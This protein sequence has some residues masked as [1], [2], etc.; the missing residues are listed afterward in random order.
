MVGRAE[1]SVQAARSRSGGV[2]MLTWR[3]GILL[4]AGAAV[5]LSLG[6]ARAE[7][8]VKIGLIVPMTGGQASTGKQIDNAVKLYMQQK[9]DPVAGKKIEVILKD[10]AAVPA[11][12]KRPAQELIVNDK[13]N[14]IAGFG[15]TP[16]PL[17]AAPLATQAKVPE[18]VMAAGTSIITER[19]P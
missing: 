4:A 10:D 16:A 9:G 14:F 8:T 2:L 5:A 17:A 19:S 11:N 13:V 18:I 12:T 3:R 7:D 6:P 1:D 15:V